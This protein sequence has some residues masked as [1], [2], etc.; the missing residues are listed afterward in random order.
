MTPHDLE[1]WCATNQLTQKELADKLGI[2]PN[3]ISIYKRNNH[4][5]KWFPLALKQLEVK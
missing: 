2:T 3:T 4:F 1:I 5:P